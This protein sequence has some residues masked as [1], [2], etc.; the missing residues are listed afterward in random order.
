VEQARTTGEVGVVAALP[1][2]IEVVVFL[3]GAVGMTLEL[4]GSRL[5]APYFGNS[6]FVWTSLIGVML[7]FMAIGNFLGGRLADRYL[8]SSLLFWILTGA[9]VSISAI[10][11]TEGSVLPGL[12]DGSPSRASAVA[13]AVILFAVPSTLLGMVAPYCIRLRMHALAHSGATVG[14]L[15][16]LS[17]V[18][19]IVGTFAAG[20]WLIATMGS[21]R[22]VVWLAVIPLALSLAFAFPR[23]RKRIAASIL[24]AAAL[25]AAILLPRPLEG[26]FD[27]QYDRY[28]IGSTT[29]PGTMRQVVHLARGFD[30]WESAV[31]EDDKE[32]FLF[33]YYA[34][35]DLAL[36]M[37]PAPRRTLMIGGGTFSY[38][39]H[40]LSEYPTSTTDVV[41]IDP[42]LVD[43]ARQRF[44]LKDDPRMRIVVE[45]GRTFLNRSTT[46]YDAILIDAFKSANSIPYQLTTVESMRRC[47][48]MLDED[49]ILALNTIASTSGDGSRFVWA[50]Y[51]TL[52]AVF[53]QVEVFLVQDPTRPDVVQNVSLIASKDPS[54]DL[55]AAIQ[56][57]APDLAKNRVTGVAPPA[58]T[59]V[60]TD[61][62][63]PVDQLLLGI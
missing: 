3:G 36:K 34:F 50:E 40:Q 16:A 51:A 26:S 28:M 11:F 59:S 53:P 10:A 58:G 23:D 56:R 8:S 21:H 27:T 37:S 61:D 46:T 15:Y 6:I 62:F 2:V 47:A 17:T 52:R 49:G 44:G 39:R 32:P 24:A 19:S 25:L 13:A 1:Y 18:G 57:A 33:A 42:A 20:F 38:P 54:I 14:S 48:D 35:Y 9:S 7:G 29:E 60:M 43:V 30:S 55:A 63:A 45:D 5:L 31:Y 22:I 4:V 41:E 12:A